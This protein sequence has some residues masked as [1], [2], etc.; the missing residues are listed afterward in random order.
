[1]SVDDEQ[2]ILA[3]MNPPLRDHVCLVRSIG[4]LSCLD[5]MHDTEL[6]GAIAHSVSRQ[7]YM[8]DDLIMAEDRH[9]PGMFFINEGHVEIVQRVSRD[10]AGAP[11][12]GAAALLADAAAGQAARGVPSLARD[13]E[14]SFG[15]KGVGDFIGEMALLD[16]GSMIASASVRV[17]EFCETLLLEREAFA[18]LDRYFPTLRTHLEEVARGR[19]WTPKR[20]TDHA[21]DC[22]LSH[23]WARDA[24][25]RDTHARAKALAE[26][27]ES[28][29]DLR[30]WLDEKEMKG[31]VNREM[32]KGIDDSCVVLV[33][34]TEAYMAKVNGQGAGESNDS[35]RATGCA[36]ARP[37]ASLTLRPAPPCARARGRL[38]AGV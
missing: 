17:V 21:Y 15:I 13:G 11:A 22:F 35:A 23:A 26:Q 30:A 20:K 25:E 1:M 6:A 3:Y 10:G 4:L 16:G 5:V 32:T 27:L 18:R 2:A 28:H 9:S 37:R 38:Q 8:H 7:V 19:G 29:Y 36:S 24:E 33:L 14:R 12:R 34:V 31:D